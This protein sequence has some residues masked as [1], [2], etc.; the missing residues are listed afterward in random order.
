MTN[1]SKT[2]THTKTEKTY[3]GGGGYDVADPCSASTAD[4]WIS[5]QAVPC[6]KMLTTAL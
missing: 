2:E 1:L 4:M 6:C 5:Q 3:L